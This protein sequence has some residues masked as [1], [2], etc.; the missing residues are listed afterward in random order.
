MRRHRISL[1]ALTLFALVPVAARAQAT[2][3]GDGTTTSSVGRGTCSGHG[4]VNAK[5]TSAA[6]KAV[7]A[8][9]KRAATQ[10]KAEAKAERKASKT[11]SSGEVSAT[12]VACKD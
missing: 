2:V 9:E 4:G 3:C 11:E 8:A 5:A 6:K 12:V 7:K 10:A 1:L